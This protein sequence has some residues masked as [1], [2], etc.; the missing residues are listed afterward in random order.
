MSKY[1]I[2][3]LFLLASAAS[4][5]VDG[6]SASGDKESARISKILLAHYVKQIETYERK[7]EINRQINMFG[8]N[9]CYEY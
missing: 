3:D 5:A 9:H 2:D 1:K 7:M 8:V 6:H 4:Q